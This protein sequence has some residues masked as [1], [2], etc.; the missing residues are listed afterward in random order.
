V[1][2]ARVLGRALLPLTLL[3]VASAGCSGETVAEALAGVPRESTASAQRFVED[4]YRDVLSGDESTCERFSAAGREDFVA[5]MNPA[6]S[7]EEAVEVLSDVTADHLDE[8]LA[9]HTY[10]VE[11]EAGDTVIVRADFGNYADLMPVTWD[12]AN[13]LAGPTERIESKN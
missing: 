1:K 8:F 12:G 7:C 6:V 13:W 9:T 5:D 10:T 11:T 3:T 4:L 2:I